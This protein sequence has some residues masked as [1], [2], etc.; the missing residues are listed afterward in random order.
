MSTSN[1]ITIETFS[2]GNL[3]VFFNAF[4]KKSV[5]FKL[6]IF[7]HACN[8]KRAMMQDTSTLKKYTKL[9]KMWSQLPRGSHVRRKPYKF[10]VITS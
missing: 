10:S 4:L 6:Y 8:K 1:N 5:Y 9:I 3:T 2:I 7:K